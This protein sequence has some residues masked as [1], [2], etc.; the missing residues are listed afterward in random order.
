MQKAHD[1]HVERVVRHGGVAIFRLDK[2]DAY[3][4]LRIGRRDFKS[5]ERLRKDS[6]FWRAS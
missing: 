6:R 1:A 2:V 4:V 3:K 5:E